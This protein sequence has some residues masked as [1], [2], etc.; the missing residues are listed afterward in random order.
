MVLVNIQDLKYLENI[1][2]IFVSKF[3]IAEWKFI[4]WIP[5]LPPRLFFCSVKLYFEED[6]NEKYFLLTLLKTYL[7]WFRICLC[8]TGVLQPSLHCPKLSP[9]SCSTALLV[10]QVV[11]LQRTRKTIPHLSAHSDE[12]KLMKINISDNSAAPSASPVQEEF[13]SKED[14]SLPVWVDWHHPGWNC[15][16]WS[17]IWPLFF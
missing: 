13:K 14:L 7:G 1:L 15:W 16:C 11:F 9:R 12:W 4:E 6:Q 5:S 17:P 10:T 2:F 3:W 8:K